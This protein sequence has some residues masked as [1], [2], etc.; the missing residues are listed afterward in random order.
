[1]SNQ[2]NQPPNMYSAT[3][4][5]HFLNPKHV[6]VLEKYDALGEVGNV[7]CGDIMR[8]YLKIDQDQNQELCI[9]DI[10]FETYGCGAAI[11]T[12]SYT[13][14]LAHGKKLIDALKIEKN[15]IIA[16]L[17]S[18]PPQKIHCSILA[19][20][21]LK[22]AIYQYYFQNKIKIPP[23]LEKIHQTLLKQKEILQQQYKNWLK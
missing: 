14:E 12:S 16:G 2:N 6:G 20:D 15:D 3:V 21:A 11:A 1:M 10:S 4:M 9:S 23:T 17:E 19:V 8:I 13:C 5:S 18:L 7:V 22:E